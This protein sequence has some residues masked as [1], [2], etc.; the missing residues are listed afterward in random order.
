M[1]GEI[2]HGWCL[3]FHLCVNV[4]KN[5]EQSGSFRFFCSS[6]KK[7]SHQ[8]EKASEAVVWT[9]LFL[10]ALSFK[11]FETKILLIVNLLKEIHTNG[12]PD[13]LAII[14]C[15]IGQKM[16]TCE[17]LLQNESMRRPLKR[18][19]SQVCISTPLVL[20]AKSYKSTSCKWHALRCRIDSD[21]SEN[22]WK[23][24]FQSKI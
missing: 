15:Q 7:R 13:V 5:S 24:L 9:G 12:I 17:W 3:L 23:I 19:I 21:K 1:H 14:E 8:Y 18:L 4:F 2:T 16:E 22:K 10:V 11:I 20:A 6:H